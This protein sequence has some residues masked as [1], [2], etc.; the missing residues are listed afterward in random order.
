MES[1]LAQAVPTPV[2]AHQRIHSETDSGPF[3]SRGV[4]R[5]IRIGSAEDVAC[6]CNRKVQPHAKQPQP[7]A[8]LY[9]RELPHR[10]RHF[11]DRRQY[12][13][14]SGADTRSFT[15]LFLKFGEIVG[16]IFLGRENSPQD[17]ADE[18]CRA[19]VKRKTHR[20]RNRPR[21]P[22]GADVK[23]IGQ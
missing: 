21:S 19:Y 8:D 7:G 1:V 17:R 5:R 20:K 14:R 23:N 15:L 6:H 10:V 13:A 22:G 2:E 3:H 18:R 9:P 4:Q 12:L 16:R 11:A